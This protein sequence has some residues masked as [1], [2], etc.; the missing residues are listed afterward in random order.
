MLEIK[1]LITMVNCHRGDLQM[2]HSTVHVIYK[3]FLKILK[4]IMF[5]AI[6]TFPARTHQQ[7]LRPATIVKF[8]THLLPLPSVCSVSVHVQHGLPVLDIVAFYLTT[9]ELLS[10]IH[11]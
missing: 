10:L 5:Q 8:L 1:G 6:D 9:L 4:P 2:L 7:Y 11:I 3:I